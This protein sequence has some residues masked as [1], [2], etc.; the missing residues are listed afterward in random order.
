MKLSCVLQSMLKTTSINVELQKRSP[1]TKAPKMDIEDCLKEPMAGHIRLIEEMRKLEAAPVDTMGC[2][3]LADRTAD[4][5]V[6]TVSV[7]RIL[8]SF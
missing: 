5:K 6:R 8:G 4:P 7:A 1:F 3:M 2:H